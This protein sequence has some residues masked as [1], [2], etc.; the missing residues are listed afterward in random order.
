MLTITK[1][2]DYGILF[3][4]NLIGK[5]DFIPLSELVEKT[6][7]PKRFLARIAATL[8][9]NKVVESREGKVGGYKLAKNLNKI[10][11]H[12]FLKFF[13]KDVAV[14]RCFD[15]DYCCDYE[16]ICQHQ[17]FI[18]TKLNDVLIKELKRY[19]LNDLL[20]VK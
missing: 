10:T 16:G 6:H 3:L 2:S 14:C 12:D 4:E 11:L 9:K 17:S 13:E 20:K 15:D 18:R 5:K 1:Q 19:T 8:V 7:L